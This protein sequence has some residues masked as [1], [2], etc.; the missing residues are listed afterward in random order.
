M[1]FCF[2]R[3]YCRYHPSLSPSLWTP[4]FFPLLTYKKSL[5]ITFVLFLCIFSGVR[6]VYLPICLLFL[7]TLHYSTL[8]SPSPSHF[9]L[10]HSSLLSLLLHLFMKNLVYLVFFCCVCSGRVALYCVC[11]CFRH[12]YF[13]FT[14]SPLMTSF[15]LLS[16]PHGEEKLE[17]SPS[18]MLL[19]VYLEFAIVSPLPIVY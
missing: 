8:S 19:I 7:F 1:R 10:S 4:F 12:K 17:P 13:P 3:S 18:F 14:P 16:T 11:F 9:T 6:S 15:S 5:S 2:C